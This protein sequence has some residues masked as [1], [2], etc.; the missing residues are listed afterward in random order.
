LHACR[1]FLN[2]FSFVG[3]MFCIIGSTVYL[4]ESIECDPSRNMHE[5]KLASIAELQHRVD[6]GELFFTGI[7]LEFVSGK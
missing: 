2:N 7:I 1:T 5:N 6:L 4:H 3:M